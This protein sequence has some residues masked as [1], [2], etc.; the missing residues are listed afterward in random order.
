[1]RKTV[2]M[3]TF[4]SLLLACSG[5][6]ADPAFESTSV[7]EIRVFGGDCAQQR[8]VAVTA[9]VVGS[10][11]GQG[12]CELYGP[13][14]PDDLKPLASSGS[15]EM[16]PDEETVWTAELPGGAPPLSDLNPVCEPM[17]EG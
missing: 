12:S 2:F 3:A 9:S 6:E 5:S 14:D 7:T 15:L 11:E 8:C 16:I 13:G 1:M 4:L 17:I 10:R